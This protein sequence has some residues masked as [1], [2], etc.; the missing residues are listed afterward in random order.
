MTLISGD[1]QLEYNGLVIGDDIV[2]FCEEITGWDD[3]PELET[4]RTDW[5]MY[6]GG[7]VGRYYARGRTIT[8][9]GVVHNL[10][11]PLFPNTIAGIRAAFTANTAEAQIPIY[12]R[13]HDT[14]LVAYGS[15]VKRSIPNDRVFGSVRK[16]S[17]ALQFF[18]PD[19]RKYTTY[20]ATG[21]TLFP[22]VSGDGL[23]YPLVYPLDYGDPVVTGEV[24]MTNLGDAPA[25]V[26]YTVTGPCTNPSIWNDTTSAHVTFYVTLSGDESLVVDTGAQTAKIG[27]ADRLYTKSVESSPLLMMEL[28]PG[29]NSIRATATSWSSEASLAVSAPAGAYF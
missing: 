4:S 19:P 13:T 24:P 20:L 3:L 29:G 9:Q 23:D 1:G 26:V 18:C 7:V 15:C 6:H 2:S 16:A 28:A 12:V 8:W 21:S 14:T 25:P 10:D 11:S 27:S 5:A 22:S 17:L